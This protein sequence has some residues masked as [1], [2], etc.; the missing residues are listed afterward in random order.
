[1]VSR[2]GLLVLVATLILAGLVIALIG[3]QRVF[4]DAETVGRG[5]SVS[6]ALTAKDNPAEPLPSVEATP[7]PV[8]FAT[9]SPVGAATAST[10]TAT[11]PILAK[12]PPAP[13]PLLVATPTSTG[14][15]PDPTPGSAAKPV[16][17]QAAPAPT[18]PAASTAK[19]P[20]AVT[21]LGRVVGNGCYAGHKEG[22]Q[23]PEVV[24]SV[25][26]V[27]TCSNDSY[28]F[29]PAPFSADN[30]LANTIVAFYG[31]RAAGSMGILGEHPLPELERRLRE[32]A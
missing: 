4:V 32:Q 30:P 6:V 25:K 16:P 9:G 23:W 3:Q 1:M 10:A 20:V 31:N 2:I 18:P 13:T 22:D 24:A 28:Y 8:S 14:R 15:S 26:G 19:T 21:S 17:A 27:V 11:V 12:E 29:K 5:R 7:S